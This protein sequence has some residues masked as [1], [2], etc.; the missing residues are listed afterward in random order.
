MT[1]RS[2]QIPNRWY[3]HTPLTGDGKREIHSVRHD[4]QKN[5]E[6]STHDLMSYGEEINEEWMI[7]VCTL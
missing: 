5:F 2:A 7:L 1:L 3:P 6:R 4:H